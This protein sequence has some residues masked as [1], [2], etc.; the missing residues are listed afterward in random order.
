MKKNYCI[1]QRRDGTKAQG[2]IFKW[3]VTDWEILALF[4]FSMEGSWY[5]LLL[6][7]S[8]WSFPFSQG[9]PYHVSDDRMKDV[10]KGLAG[11]RLGKWMDSRPS[12]WQAIGNPSE[13]HRFAKHSKI[14]R[15]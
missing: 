14:E 4:T 9:I 8:Q 13:L 3:A 6:A 10:V 15:P 1:W 11:T 2:H 5:A 12:S 7:F